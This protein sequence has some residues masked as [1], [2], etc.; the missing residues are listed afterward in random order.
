MDKDHTD[1]HGFAKTFK[2][3]M[4][5]PRTWI[6]G[7]VAGYTGKGMLKGAG[8]SL[9]SGM[10][11]LR[12]AF[13]GT[14][15]ALEK[16]AYADL[17]F[18]DFDK[19]SGIGSLGKSALMNAL[20]MAGAG[21]LGDKESRDRIGIANTFANRFRD[22]KLWLASTAVGGAMKGYEHLHGKAIKGLAAKSG[23]K[24]TVGRALNSKVGKILD[25]TGTSMLA[26]AVYPMAGIP[27]PANYVWEKVGMPD[28]ELYSG[29]KGRFWDRA[30]S[31]KSPVV[32]DSF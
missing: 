15:N 13:N 7:T 26:F 18:F 2:H 24:G 14:A 23:I 25:P 1:V 31:Y 27:V 4:T 19:M 20:F 9:S 32:K 5:D 16:A 10:G 17:S 28:S 30:K 11:K 3:K 6:A 21:T 22:P 29:L 12:G 8:K